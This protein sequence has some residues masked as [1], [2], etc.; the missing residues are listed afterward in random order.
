MLNYDHCQKELGFRQGGE[1]CKPYF[2][3]ERMLPVYKP[4]EAKLVYLSFAQRVMLQWSTT[5]DES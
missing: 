2:D 4:F 5:T 1:L 3:E